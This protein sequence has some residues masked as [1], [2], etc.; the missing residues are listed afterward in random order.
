MIF[1][2]AKRITEKNE[3]ELNAWKNDLVVV[4]IDEVGRGCLAGPVVAA[5]VILQPW[6]H[7]DL[8]VDSKTL[9]PLQREKACAW[10]IQHSVYACATIDHRTIDTCNIVQATKKAMARSFY[11]LIAHKRQQLNKIDKVL[12][13]AVDINF[14][15]IEPDRVHAFYHGEDYSV[16]IA[17]ASIVAKVFRD[18]LMARLTTQFPAY[19]FESHKGYG[20]EKHRAAL[21]TNGASII[22]RRTFIDHL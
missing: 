8:L 13:D 15:V 21:N 11:Q 22:H 16:S 2:P 10:I 3:F 18:R 5:S 17:A 20:T 4:G 6:A 9:T 1:L 19:E 7:H 14:D 12:I